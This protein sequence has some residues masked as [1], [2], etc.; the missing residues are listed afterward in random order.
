MIYAA[1]EAAKRGI[2]VFIDAG[3]ADP[4]FPLSSLPELE[5]FSPNESETAAFTGIDPIN[6]Q[7]C[8]EAVDRLKKLVRAKFYVLKLGSRGAFISDGVIYKHIESYPVTAIDTTAAGD[9]FTAALTLRYLDDGDITASAEYACAVGAITVSRKG[10]S[11]S[12]PSAREVEKFLE[13]RGE[14]II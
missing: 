8:L 14:Y 3:P 4:S 6:E 10:A 7:K 1:N 12:V 9:A 2:P 11:S 5:I 13:E